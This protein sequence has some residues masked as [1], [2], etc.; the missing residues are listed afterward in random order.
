[1]FCVF[2]YTTNWNLS[3]F[4]LPSQKLNPSLGYV[5]FHVALLEYNLHISSH[6]WLFCR[7]LSDI[8]RFD[9]HFQQMVP[10]LLNYNLLFRIHTCTS[11]ILLINSIYSTYSSLP[12]SIR[13]ADT[14]DRSGGFCTPVK[15]VQSE[16]S[17]CLRRLAAIT[18]GSGRSPHSNPG[19]ASSLLPAGSS[20]LRSFRRSSRSCSCRRSWPG[21]AGPGG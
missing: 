8:L 14:S 9:N 21:W 16:V 7:L 2:D 15:S 1:M 11:S 17:N 19:R 5:L 10:N 6:L 18:P 4:I 3:N 12:N 13:R 20:W